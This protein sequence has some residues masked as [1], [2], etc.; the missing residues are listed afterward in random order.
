MS[1]VLQSAKGMVSTVTEETSVAARTKTL[2]KG[3][4]STQAQAL[5][6]ETAPEASQEQ[7]PTISEASVVKTRTLAK[8]Q[9]HVASRVMGV[10]NSSTHKALLRYEIIKNIKYKTK[11]PLQ[12]QSNS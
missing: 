2:T 10:N 12:G 3:S 1:Q 7:A 6:L 8:S 4:A 11:V 5:V 9:A